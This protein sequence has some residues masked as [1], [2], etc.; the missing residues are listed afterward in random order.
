MPANDH[1]TITT[2]EGTWAVGRPDGYRLVFDQ[3]DATQA[4]SWRAQVTSYIQ[5]T[6]LLTASIDLLNLRDRTLYHQAAAAMNGQHAC[7]WDQFLMQS[8]R[9]I[10][11][12]LA[13]TAPRERWPTPQPLP[14][15]LPEVPRLPSTILP[16]V[17]A[18]FADDLA[19]RM[20]VPLDYVGVA[21]TIAVGSLIGRQCGIYPKRCDDWL[22][23][24]N[25]WGA[26]IGR[27]GLMK[28]PTLLQAMK[29]LDYLAAQ[30]LD[31]AEARA[32]QHAIDREV[33]DAQLAGVRDAL[34]KAAKDAQADVM[35]AKTQELARIQAQLDLLAVPP[36]R[37]K[38]NDVTIQK[39]GELLRDNPTGLLLYRDELSGWLSSLR[40]EG[41]DGDRDFFLETWSGD[42]NYMF[43]R[44]GR[45]SIPVKGLCLS[46]LGGLQPG[47]L[48]Q[49][50]QASTDGGVEDDGLL[51]RLQ[52][53]VWPTH[54]PTFTNVDRYPDR[55]ARDAVYA[56]FARLADFD[57]EGLGA[58][59]ADYQSV[60]AL[61][62]TDEGQALFDAWREAL[63]TRIRSG[64]LR[65][66]AFE[67]HLAKYRSLMPSLA[68]IF[69]LIE[70]VSGTTTDTM[71]GIACARL[72]A[73]WCEFLEAHACKVYA[74]VLQKDLQAAYALADKINAHGVT[75]GQTVR[76]IYRNGWA[77]LR[78]HDDVYG[79]LATLQRLGWLRV[80]EHTTAAKGGRPREVIQ[81]HPALVAGGFVSFV[82]RGGWAYLSFFGEHTGVLSVLS[83]GGMHIFIHCS[84]A[85]DA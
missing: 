57:A 61:R 28:S 14:G 23:V 22:V 32:S 74:G 77:L 50:V 64:E 5:E 65:S 73:S 59:R 71:V 35:A 2:K 12:M 41:R 48:A 19:S 20:Q 18:A 54:E 10:Q 39:L 27:P 51:Q 4:R 1:L 7:A 81:L 82:S 46:L 60:P 34:K 15:L 79:G 43:D 17:F 78:T 44:V 37:F 6:E 53:L 67:S 29:P 40:Q 56:L 9:G 66:P 3:V 72:A 31:E 26:V 45:G 25:L 42:G 30:A 16:R 83:V 21:L 8:Y 84:R 47:K 80:E 24:P 70:A 36:R 55:D 68:L 38:T 13:A 52:L 49:Y 85:R 62:F 11:A 69:H 75:D 76:E 33:L 58:S 63:E